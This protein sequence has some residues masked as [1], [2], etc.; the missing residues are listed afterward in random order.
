M[1]SDLGEHSSW[2]DEAHRAVPGHSWGLRA[3][4]RV[5][6]KL[7]GKLSTEGA[8]KPQGGDT[9]EFTSWSTHGIVRQCLPLPSI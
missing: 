2:D 4:E 3:T 7:A 5:P 1:N 6:T 8:E 9:D